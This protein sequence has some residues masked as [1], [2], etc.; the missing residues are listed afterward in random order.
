[1]SHSL[2]TA[3][4][5]CLLTSQA[6]NKCISPKIKELFSRF[7][8]DI[9]AQQHLTTQSWQNS[10]QCDT[11]LQSQGLLGNVQGG[12][13]KATQC[14]FHALA[15]PC[16]TSPP[17]GSQVLSNF[18]LFPSQGTGDESNPLGMPS[19]PS[20]CLAWVCIF[21]C[22]LLILHVDGF[23]TGQTLQFQIP[24]I[25]LKMTSMT[26]SYIIL[27]CMILLQKYPCIAIQQT[28][29]KINCFHWSQEVASQDCFKRANSSFG[30]DLTV[31]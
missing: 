14:R 13:L 27:L 20:L 23:P 22:Y 15:R 10:K 19:L 16:Q 25:S 12:G 1:M 21:C 24:L 31:V 7:F 17:S 3:F 8:Y 11:P 4:L 28:R 18:L 6:W 2:S 30:N 9:Q 26:Y 29:W 5:F